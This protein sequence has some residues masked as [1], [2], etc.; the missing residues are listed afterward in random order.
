MAP[1]PTSLKALR[2]IEANG[3]LT[4]AKRAVYAHLV[5]NGPMTA[6]EL[7]AQMKPPNQTNPSYHKRLS[8]LE[9]LGVVHRIGTRPCKITGHN[10]IVW[11]VTDNLPVEKPTK[12]PSWKNLVDAFIESITFVS[13]GTVDKPFS[14]N[15]CNTL[16]WIRKYRE[17][18]IPDDYMQR[19]MA[20]LNSKKSHTLETKTAMLPKITSTECEGTKYYAF[21]KK[22]L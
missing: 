10:A 11:E 13:L 14:Q 18:Y 12:K 1:K 17:N 7:T 21:T 15:L 2:I 16:T 4:F 22:P 20:I 19:H 9:A 6:G 8:E 5:F 3:S